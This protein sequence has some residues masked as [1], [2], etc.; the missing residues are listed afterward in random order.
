[1]HVV[2]AVFVPPY[3]QSFG[4]LRIVF[5]ACMSRT[6]LQRIPPPLG[7]VDVLRLPLSLLLVGVDLKLP[8]STFL[9]KTTLMSTFARGLPFRSAK[10]LY[11]ARTRI[12]VAAGAPHSASPK[13][14]SL[15]LLFGVGLSRFGV[16]VPT[17]PTFEV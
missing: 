11:P 6:S 13:P 16:H 1:M 12:S 4:S 15:P 10:S 17:S 5:C 14:A 8:P 2:A 3:T 9:P 7:T